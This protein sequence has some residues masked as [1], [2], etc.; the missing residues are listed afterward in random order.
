MLTS[1]HF[2]PVVLLE[3]CEFPKGCHSEETSGEFVINDVELLHRQLGT[4]DEWDLWVVGR[5]GLEG[6]AVCGMVYVDVELSI[7]TPDDSKFQIRSSESISES[8]SELEI[9]LDVVMTK[10]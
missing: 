2:S 3:G 5:G 8:K 4:G 6:F 1:G 9:G 7:Q 10:K